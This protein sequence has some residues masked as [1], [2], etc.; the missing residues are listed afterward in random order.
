MKPDWQE[1]ADQVQGW[2]A[3]Q[4]LEPI[5]EAAAESEPD[6]VFVEIGVWKGCSTV[7]IAPE[8][9]G[10]RYVAV[11]HFK[12]SEGDPLHLADPELPRIQEIF[13]Q[14]LK[15]FE[16]EDRVEILAED[17]LA[18]ANQFEEASIDIVLLDA[19]HEYQEVRADIEAW[20]PKIK[21]GGR[22]FFHD[23]GWE[24]VRKAIEEAELPGSSPTPGLFIARKGVP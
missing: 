19:G 7:A 23:W 14:N 2:F 20:W 22:M 17:S 11:D 1:R 24:G 3:Y 21:V 13:E 6:D 10:H 4:E 8:F 12:G 9:Q 16:L 5:I 15:N 18:A